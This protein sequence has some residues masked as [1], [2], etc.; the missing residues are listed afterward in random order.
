MR[1][2]WGDKVGLDCGVFVP[3]RLFTLFD[4]NPDTET[5]T[6]KNNVFG[7]LRAAAAATAVRAKD[8]LLRPNHAT[9]CIQPLQLG[10]QLVLCLVFST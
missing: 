9:P 4:L 5:K 10:Y 6:T 7:P 3:S 1:V 8:D 2:F